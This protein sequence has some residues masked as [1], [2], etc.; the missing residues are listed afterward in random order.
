[1][2][3]KP[4]DISLGFGRLLRV[5]MTKQSRVY[6]PKSKNIDNPQKLVYIRHAF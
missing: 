4:S 3:R 6:E 1:M 5:R 2:Y